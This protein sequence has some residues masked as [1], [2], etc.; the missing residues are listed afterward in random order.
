M[1]TNKMKNIMKQGTIETILG[2]IVI[3]IAAYFLTFAYNLSDSSKATSGYFINAS[4]QNI[5]GVEKGNEVK[6]SGIK[7]GYVDSILLEKDTY[8]A[9]VKLVIDKNVEVPKDSRA[10][11]AT[12]GLIGGRYIRINP[13]A[14]DE[15]L[16][17]NEKI[18]YT[19]SALSIEDLI[20]KLVYSMTS[21]SK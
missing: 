17:D 12:N 14:A 4:F 18:I 7:V 10:T 5:D 13:G 19:Q 1:A 20:S 21:G 11:V 15:T 16:K 8:S 9:I 3:A 2:F 6:I